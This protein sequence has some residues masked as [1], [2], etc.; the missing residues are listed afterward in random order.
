M[1]AFTAL[2][3]DLVV[4]WRAGKP[5][6]NGQPP[7]HAISDGDGNRCR[8]CLDLI[9]KGAPFLIVA[10]RPFAH[11]HPYAELG[12]LFVCAAP[13]PRHV[14]DGAL[15]RAMTTSPEYLIKGYFADERIIYGTGQIVTPDTMITA[16]RTLFDDPAVA[17][18]HIRS[19]RN[20]CYQ[21]RIDRS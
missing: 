12:P 3:T 15:P 7:E 21:A 19:A 10:H 16:A 18:I 17:F 5:D 8:H 1:P 20:N 14:D 13:C 2:P 6:A 4:A 11:L 9:P